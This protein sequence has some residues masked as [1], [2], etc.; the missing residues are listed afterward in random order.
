MTFQT[1]AAAAF[2]MRPSYRISAAPAA[3]VTPGE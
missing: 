2:M 1:G 3:L